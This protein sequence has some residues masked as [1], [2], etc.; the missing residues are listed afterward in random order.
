MALKIIGAGY[1]RTGT[2]SLKIALEQLG[3]GP[4]YHMAEILMKP[5]HIRKWLDASNGNPDWDGILGG[6]Q[7]VLDFPASTYWRELAD[8]FPD[9]KVLLSVRDAESWAHS[10]S[11]TILSQRMH[12]LTKGTLFGEMIDKTTRVHF[13]QEVPDLETLKYAFEKHNKDVQAGVRSSRLLTFD[14]KEGWN[15]LCKFLDVP[16]PETGFPRVNSSEEFDEAFSFLGT[17]KGRRALE[18]AYPL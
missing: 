9:A 4:C 11:N 13:G 5:R 15:P 2:S 3:F 16:V 6:Y 10:A 12:D 8:Y 18:G 14:V 7:S 1:G 17:T